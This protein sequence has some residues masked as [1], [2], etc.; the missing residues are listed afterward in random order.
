LWLGFLHSGVLAYGWRASEDVMAI[1]RGSADLLFHLARVQEEIH[2]WS[3]KLAVDILGKPG[4]M[5]YST[6]LSGMPV[7]ENQSF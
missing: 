3:F 2:P 1:I 6:S 4:R 7:E 5:F